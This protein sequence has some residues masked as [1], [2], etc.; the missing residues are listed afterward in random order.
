MSTCNDCKFLKDAANSKGKCKKYAPDSHRF[1][2]SHGEAVKEN[3]WP[4]IDITTTACNEFEAK[5]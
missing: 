3:G 5:P 1:L 4:E 2:G